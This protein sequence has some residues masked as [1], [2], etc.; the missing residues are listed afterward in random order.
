MAGH[1]ATARLTH[2]VRGVR[3]QDVSPAAWGTCPALVHRCLLCR[4]TIVCSSKRW[5][6]HGGSSPRTRGAARGSIRP[7]GRRAPLPNSA[8]VFAC[9]ESSARIRPADHD[10]GVENPYPPREPG[11]SGR[12]ERHSLGER[13]AVH[14]V[15]RV[16]DDAAPPGRVDLREQLRRSV[17]RAVVDDDYL[18]SIPTRESG[19]AT[20]ARARP[21]LSDSCETRD[22]TILLR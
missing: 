17:R 2:W 20:T 4:S 3:G 11:A 7:R 1:E 19:A 8:L 5:T 21:S 14:G 12:E 10:V 13:R 16:R 18:E 15:A 22:L 9:V 6:C